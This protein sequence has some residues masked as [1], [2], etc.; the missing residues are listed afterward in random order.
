MILGAER[1]DATSHEDGARADVYGLERVNCNSYGRV[2]PVP[3]L[4]SSLGSS[5]NND[6]SNSSLFQMPFDV[7]API[8][9]VPQEDPALFQAPPL[10]LSQ[11]QYKQSAPTTFVTPDD[12]PQLFPGIETQPMSKPSAYFTAPQL[13]HSS[14]AESEVISTFTLTQDPFRFSEPDLSST[15]NM[16]ED[17]WDNILQTISEDGSNSPVEEQ[18]Q[19]N[20]LDAPHPPLDLCAVDYAKQQ[21]MLREQNHACDWST[22]AMPVL[23]GFEAQ[24]ESQQTFI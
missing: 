19:S 10:D 6:S 8:V 21:P 1:L 16:G 7:P 22:W 14:S 24:L 3:S 5:N 4:S 12:L 23:E 15:M 11:G 18:Q 20:D 13:A 2:S 9:R 17:Y